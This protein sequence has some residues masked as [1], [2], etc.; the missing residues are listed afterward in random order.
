MLVVLVRYNSRYPRVLLVLV[1]EERNM[2]GDFLPVE[3][4]YPELLNL[5]YND[6]REGAPVD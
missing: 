1:V 6:N 5:L 4:V 3:E 2:C